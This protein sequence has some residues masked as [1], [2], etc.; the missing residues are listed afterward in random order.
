[1]TEIAFYTEF[2]FCRGVDRETD[3]RTNQQVD[4]MNPRFDSAITQKL[5]LKSKEGKI[6]K[7]KKKL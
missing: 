2:N 4:R 6:I 1:M 7:N 3:R 5:P